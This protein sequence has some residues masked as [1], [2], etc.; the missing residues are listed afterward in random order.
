MYRKNFFKF[1]KDSCNGTLFAPKV[2]PTFSKEEAD[3]YFKA[4]YSTPV[5]IDT[6]KLDW[7]LPTLP[8]SVSY[9]T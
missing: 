1:A 3:T 9:D 7:M 8:P 4:K 2:T 5:R 6:S